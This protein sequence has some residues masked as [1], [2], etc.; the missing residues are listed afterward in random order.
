MNL[1]RTLLLVVLASSASAQQATKPSKEEQ[2]EAA[3]IENRLVLEFDG[4]TFSGPAYGRLL[5][6][7]ARAQFFLIG[8]EHGIAE[9]PML[10]GQL[11]TDLTDHGYSKMAVEISPP[12]ATILDDA[13]TIGGLDALRDLYATPGGE[14]AFFG[15]KEEAE[16][17][18]LFTPQ[19]QT[20]CPCSGERTTR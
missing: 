1:F 20:T 17:L 14:P 3:A 2:L 9:N 4:E 6:E 11:F 7:G 13:L 8:E 16:I 18:R 15:M 5:D 12:V 10:A 19:C